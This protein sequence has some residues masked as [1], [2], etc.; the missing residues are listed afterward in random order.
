MLLHSDVTV[1]LVTVV[2]GMHVNAKDALHMMESFLRKLDSSIPLSMGAQFG[3]RAVTSID[4]YADWLVCFK[5][6]MAVFG[7][8]ERNGSDPQDDAAEKL[9]QYANQHPGECVLICI[10]PLT[11]I[12]KAMALDALFP[13]KI[14]TLIIMGGALDASLGIPIDDDNNKHD[15]DKQI[16]AELNF[17]CDPSSAASVLNQVAFPDV[18]LVPLDTCVKVTEDTV[19]QL[20]ESSPS[21]PSTFSTVLY[22]LIRG[23]EGEALRYDPLVVW[24][25]L[26]PDLCQ[27]ESTTLQVDP[28]TGQMH[29]VDDQA[30]KS[31]RVVRGVD[32]AQ[33]LDFFR[34]VLQAP[35]KNT[36]W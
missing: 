14:K 9:V 5:Q 18:V 25:L 3:T 17:W 36:A 6:S 30:S 21:E 11:N 29:M 35:K 26:H 27:L 32:R 28:Q 10:G 13:T 7:H 12:A 4:W 33:Y 24:Y 22:E 8:K 15:D 23:S 34:A 2:H 1:D 20:L 19:T 31:I 16:R